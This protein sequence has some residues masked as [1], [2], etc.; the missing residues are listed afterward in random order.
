MTWPFLY[1]AGE[2]LSYAELAA[3][4]LDGDLIEVG[5]AFMPAD[6]VET[7][8]LRAGSLRHLVPPT[9]AVTRWSAAWVHGAVTDP[10]S[11]HTVQ[12][13]SHQRIHH[14]TDPRLAY[15]DQLLP[16]DEVIRVG[17]ISLTPPART[18]A[19][20][21]RDLH[22]G[23][24]DAP[25]LIQALIAWDPTLAAEAAAWLEHARPMHFKRPALAS[26]RAWAQE[27]VTR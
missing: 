20:L 2:R 9:A 1:F 19:D 14:V 10:P 18:L 24:A 6:A 25:A 8:E 22:A 21:A 12:R 3:A 5:E 16:P 27:E 17:G 26:L 11:R 23:D 13:A 15:R 4:R 7:R